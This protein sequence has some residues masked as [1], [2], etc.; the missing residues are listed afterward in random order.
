MS[1]F[2]PVAQVSWHSRLFPG[3]HGYFSA[4][5]KSTASPMQCILEQVTLQWWSQEHW[6]QLSLHHSS[7]ALLLCSFSVRL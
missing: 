6:L 5:G 3:K 7:M 4:W 2:F 1:L